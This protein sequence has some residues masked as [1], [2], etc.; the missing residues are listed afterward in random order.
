MEQVRRANVR[1]R[2]KNVFNP[3]GSGTR[4]YPTIEL[5]STLSSPHLSPSSTPAGTP[6]R[7]SSPSPSFMLQNGYHGTSQNRRSPTAVTVK[8][9][10]TIINVVSGTKRSKESP[11]F[12]MD[13]FERLARHGVAIDL[14]TSSEKSISMAVES[15]HESDT[16]RFRRVVSSL[17]EF[18]TVSSRKLWYA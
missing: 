2:I 14:V 7:P 6:A 8:E 15:I 11:I 16:S 18:G 1:L 9:P 4:I 10:I 17:E 3:S 5:P 13:I 12:L